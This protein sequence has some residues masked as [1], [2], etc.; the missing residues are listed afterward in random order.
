MSQNKLTE[1][2]IRF[3][4]EALKA[5]F[6]SANIRLREGEYQYDLAKAIVSFQLEMYFPD[7][8]EIIKR[9]YGEEK[10]N[11]I[12]FVRKIQTI[13][14]KMEK[15]DLVRILPKKTP[16]ELQKYGLTGFKFEDNDKHRV[17]LASDAEMQQSRASVDQM[18]LKNKPNTPSILLLLEL[19]GLSAL[20][21]ASYVAIV[22]TLVQPIII[23]AVFIPAFV[24]GVLCSILLGRTL[25]NR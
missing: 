18:T 6:I 22:W 24:V 7:V 20:I 5:D 14:K 1:G 9:L 25:S 23:P 17:I 8:K 3:L 15:S 12:Q 4:R 2:E 21:V 11:D 10:T 16:W 13:L 19:S